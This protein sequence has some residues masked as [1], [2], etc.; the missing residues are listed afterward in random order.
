MHMQH[1]EINYLLLLFLYHRCQ[2]L[3]SKEN[4]YNWDCDLLGAVVC[5]AAPA[6]AVPSPSTGDVQGGPYV[7][8]HL[9]T[10]V[11]W[12]KYNYTV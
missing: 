3:D 1:T 2:S 8:L 7:A 9:H 6:D 11:M 10:M 4:I 12:A 5:S